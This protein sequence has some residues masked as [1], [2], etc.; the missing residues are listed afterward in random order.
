MQNYVNNIHAQ[1]HTA[2][3]KE[4]GVSEGEADDQ[5]VRWARNDNNVIWRMCTLSK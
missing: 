4:N 1:F 5:Q 3:V 2:T